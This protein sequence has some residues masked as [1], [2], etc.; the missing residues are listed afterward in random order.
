MK[1]KYQGHHRPKFKVVARAPYNFVPLNDV[2]VE[3]ASYLGGQKIPSFDRYHPHLFTGAI[4]Y[5]LETITPLHI[6]WTQN[7]SSEF[8]APGGRVKI[9]GSS[10][11]GMVRTLVEIV[12]WSRFVNF[13]YRR[14][15]YYRVVGDPRSSLGKKYTEQMHTCVKAGYLLKRRESYF[16]V[17]AQEI[18]GGT[19]TRE[20]DYSKDC[21]F[22]FVGKDGRYRIYSGD[23]PR[24]KAVW[25]VNPPDYSREIPVPEEDIHLYRSD[26]TRFED[27]DRA[28]K[29]GNNACTT[30]KRQRK[31]GNLLRMLEES[32][33]GVVPCFYLEWTDDKNKQ[34]FALGHTRYFRL[35]YQYN[36]GDHVPQHLR[37]HE[38]DIPEAVF[39][40]EAEFASR[41][42]FEDAEIVST[43]QDIFQSVQIVKRLDAPKPTSFQ[44]YLEQPRGK[45]TPKAILHHWNDRQ[46]L[47]RG[48]K[49]YW[50]RQPQPDQEQSTPW[51]TVQAIR[52]G[53]KF[54]GR[55]RFVNLADIELGA[56]LFCLR[57]PQGCYHKLG[58]A[59][60]I[61][62][63]TVRIKP[64][65]ILTDRQ[66]RYT[67][68]F[69][70]DNW[71]T[72]EVAP[73]LDVFIERFENYMLTELTRLGSRD[74][75]YKR[76]WDTPRLQ[77]LK[78]MLTWDH[79]SRPDWNRV[80]SY[81]ELDIYRNRPVLPKPS[82]VVEP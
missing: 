59:K 58:M 47:I 75:G 76:L 61:G 74:A 1:G 26:D 34:R 66:H 27:K 28:D 6:G 54:T 35:P 29:G 8:F 52:R 60:P 23:S 5:E 24:K 25:V 13:D 78:T 81:M 80:T 73:P 44:L 3:A 39:G 48:Y 30:S 45:N 68:L 72:A 62:L 77:E 20:E 51:K 15:L 43:D 40:C 70:A 10:L 64:I 31:D 14:G 69:N 67:T 36:I 17:P 12:S 65:L 41:V 42:Y 57:L 56:L 18:N 16:L 53:M 11:R 46:A 21:K 7:E 71:L 79:T 49:L 63:G 37:G 2:V 55:I 22:T 50:H 33:D 4:E 19:Y 9:P 32:A 82:E 38:L